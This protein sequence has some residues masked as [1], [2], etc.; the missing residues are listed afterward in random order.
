M[1]YEECVSSSIIS[2]ILLIS[3]SGNN[4]SLIYVVFHCFTA[5]NVYNQMIVRIK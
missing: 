3:C 4:Q 5:I 2:H 1:K